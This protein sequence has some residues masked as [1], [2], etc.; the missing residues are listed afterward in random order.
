MSNYDAALALNCLPKVGEIH[1]KRAKVIAYYYTKLVKEPEIFFP[2]PLVSGCPPV[3]RFYFGLRSVSLRLDD[4]GNF[5]EHN[6]LYLFAREH[7]VKL[8]YPYL[9]VPRFQSEYGDFWRRENWILSL[10]GLP[11]DFRRSFAWHDHVIEVI[12]HYLRKNGS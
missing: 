10:L 6:P 2:H 4:N 3:S 5:I 11:V 8:Y 12:R 1:S 9:P 7:G